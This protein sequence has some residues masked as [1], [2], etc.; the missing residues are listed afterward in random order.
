M[1]LA[2]SNAFANQFGG[3]SKATR[4]NVR[5]TAG[6]HVPTAAR[7]QKS[8]REEARIVNNR[9][10]VFD[11]FK[12]DGPV[13]IVVWSYLELEYRVLA[14]PFMDNGS[15]GRGSPMAWRAVQPVLNAYE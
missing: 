3:S 2:V 1:I 12:E 9:L 15:H 7:H 14:A 10:V 11:T 5:S 6:S 4:T 8:P 13:A